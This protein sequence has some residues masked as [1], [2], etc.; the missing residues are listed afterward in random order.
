[1]YRDTLSSLCLIALAPCFAAPPASAQLI[2]KLRPE[3]VSEFERYAKSVE[4]ELQRR[5]DGRSGFTSIEDSTADKQKVMSGEF[6]V[7]PARADGKPQE[8][9]DGLI[10]DWVGAVFIADTDPERVIRI[11]KDFDNHKKIYS[12]LADSKTIRS[13]GNDVV[14]YWRIQQRRGFVP[15]VL[16]VEQDAHYKELAS[17]KWNC[18]A[19]ARKI[20][21]VD[22]RR[23]GKDRLLPE[24]E[25]HGYM[26]KMY[27]YWSIEAVNG[28]VLAECR[29]LSLSRSIP[30]AIAWAVGPYVQKAPQESLAS[31]LKQTRDAMNKTAK[32]LDSMLGNVQHARSTPLMGVGILL[33]K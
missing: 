32:S 11:L 27:A 14:G 25:G 17:G 2:V 20:I 28:G 7:R 18:R 16:D 30:Q 8:V 29:M 19:Y 12:Q 26:W 9:T 10:H 13:S 3:T 24:G 6:V 5:W 22:G 15:V 4:L 21:E 33:R 31:T 1:M 23:F